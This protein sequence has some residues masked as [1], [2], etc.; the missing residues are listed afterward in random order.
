[1]F[2][3]NCGAQIDPSG[4]FCGACGAKREIQ[5]NSAPVAP[6][7]QRRRMVWLFGILAVVVFFIVFAL[8]SSGGN[9]SS[10]AG[11]T[12][13][14]ET[15]AS[16]VHHMNE[17]VNVGY[18]SYTVTRVRWGNTMGPSF[19][20][21]HA[22][23]KFLQVYIT[24]RNNDRTPSTLAPLK[25]VDPEGREYAESSKGA[26]MRGSF[27][28]LKELNPGVTSNGFVLFDVPFGTYQLLLSGGF[29]NSETARVQL[30]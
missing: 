9:N 12:S 27:D 24:I 23:A 7:K 20:P 30:E 1:M 29:E 14:T 6:S 13:A 3:C 22:D 19:A 11:T 28:I 21:E 18:W 26:L 4:Q 16:T 8:L 25:L 10:T 5:P 2:C 15:P 17:T